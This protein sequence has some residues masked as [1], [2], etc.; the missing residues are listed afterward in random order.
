MREP[1]GRR[2]QQALVTSECSRDGNEEE[3]RL[4]KVFKNLSLGLTLGK[5]MK[6]QGN[7]KGSWLW[8]IP[9]PRI[10]TSLLVPQGHPQEGTRWNSGE[11]FPIRASKRK[12]AHL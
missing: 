10:P 12:R 4:E 7:G 11:L 3:E 1:S 6:K 8:G 9:F 5:L 2:E